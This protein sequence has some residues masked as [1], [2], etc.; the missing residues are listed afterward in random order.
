MKK[1]V[2][3]SDVMQ[4]TLEACVPGIQR[5]FVDV[6]GNLYPCER[7]SEASKAVRM[8]HIDTGFDID[9]AR[10]LLNIG[11]L[12]EKECKQC[13]AFRFCSACAV[14]ADNL[15]E[16]SAEKKLQN[17]AL[18]RGHID[19]MMRDYC[20]MRDLGCNFDKEKLFV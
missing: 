12:T 10:A 9:K 1:L 6:E 7:V 5:L 3:R 18:I 14:Q 20:V 15:E 13:W 2:K 19:N 4:E 8:G 16:L 17:C 11:K